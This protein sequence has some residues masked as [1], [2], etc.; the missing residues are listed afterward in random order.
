MHSHPA[1]CLRGP[2]SHTSPS[3]PRASTESGQSA[4]DDNEPLAASGDP[5]IR[6]EL[7][8]RI[9]REIAEGVYD[10]PEKMEQALAR[11]LEKLE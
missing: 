6:W 3:W 10:T 7:V 4:I 2:V 8:Q 5:N 1:S 11:L 9:R